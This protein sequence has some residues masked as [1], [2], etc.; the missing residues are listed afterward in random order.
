MEGAGQGKGERERGEG[1][2]EGEMVVPVNLVGATAQ[3]AGA[4]KLSSSDL[5][6]AEAAEQA[7]QKK[8][9]L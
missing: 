6:D 8:A 3:A 2:G 5:R 9:K 1:A 4:K 7:K